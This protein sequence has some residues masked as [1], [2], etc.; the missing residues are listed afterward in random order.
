MERDEI[1]HMSYGCGKDAGNVI[2][3]LVA[4]EMPNGTLNTQSP[5]TCNE[6]NGKPRETV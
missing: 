3:W 2:S 1:I 6:H 4:R 5:S